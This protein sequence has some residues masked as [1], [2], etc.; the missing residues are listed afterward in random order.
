MMFNYSAGAPIAMLP[1]YLGYKLHI[2]CN[3]S[4]RFILSATHAK[5]L[6]M[7][8]SEHVKVSTISTC[9][10]KLYPYKTRSYKPRNADFTFNRTVVNLQDG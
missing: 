8:I 6:L 2:I 1:D 4:V 5:P 9:V 3:S 7:R 10:R